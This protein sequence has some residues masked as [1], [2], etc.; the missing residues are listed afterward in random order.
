[1]TPALIAAAAQR[2]AG[3]V[4]ET[5]LL[6]APALDAAAGRRVFVKAECL[7]HTGSF[8]YR[9]AKSALTALMA[10]TPPAGIIAF[11]SGNHAQGVA[12]AAAEA[13]LPAV[14]VM[15]ADAP[16]MKIDATRS[17]GAEVV[18]YDRFC[19]SREAIGERIAAERGLALVRP[20]DDPQVIAG[21]ATVGLELARQAAAIGLDRA[22]VLVPCSGGGLGSGIALALA[23]AA[24]GLRVRTVEPAGFD[25]VRLSLA[26]GIR[27]GHPAA[28]PSI[29]DA[30][31]SPMPGELTFPILSRLAGPGLAVS[32]EQCREAMA[33]AFRHLKIVLEPGGAA[34]LA[35]ALFHGDAIDAPDVVAIGSGGN[36]DPQTF[37]RA[38]AGHA[39]GAETRR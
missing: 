3:F 27:Q 33:L 6:S 13:G 39:E 31:M 14:I 11:S 7:Q 1:M 21:Q 18:L 22:E 37:C 5:P 28:A 12:R 24:P 20:F 4:R 19:E 2:I 29:C 35:A 25:D 32:D 30:L 38:L 15:P 23:D 34:A 36:V 17:L 9:G 8:K 16:Q 10:G 26:S